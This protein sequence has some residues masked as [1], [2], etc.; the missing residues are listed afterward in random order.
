LGC[1]IV[2]AGHVS[3]GA[4]LLT[5]EDV[6]QYVA[7]GASALPDGARANLTIVN[8]PADAWRKATGTELAEG[9]T[10][11]AL[12]RSAMSHAR[13]NLPPI[14]FRRSGY[15]FEHVEPVAKLTKDDKQIAIRQRALEEI[16]AW[17]SASPI[18]YPTKRSLEEWRNGLLEKDRFASK[19]ELTQAL[20]GLL[21][22]G[23]LIKQKTGKGS[24]I[25][26]YLTRPEPFEPAHLKPKKST[27]RG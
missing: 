18:K 14:Y 23:A 4:A 2:A 25:H 26:E 7:R 11:S 1:A 3:K 17:L 13:G 22:D 9:Y 20:D 5:Q 16:D 21:H 19:A 12:I 8:L 6:H 10:G 24:G 15:T 27:K